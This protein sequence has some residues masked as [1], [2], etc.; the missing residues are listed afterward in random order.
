MHFNFTNKL[1][2]FYLSFIFFVMFSI[3]YF[4]T[5]ISF[6][7]NTFLYTNKNFITE[8]NYINFF[9]NVLSDY[10]KYNFFSTFLLLIIFY[11]L[12]KIFFLNKNNQQTKIYYFT[13]LLNFLIIVCI[14]FLIKDIFYLSKNFYE[15]K[16]INRHIQ[17]IEILN[18][19]R[20][21]VNLLIIFSVIN[22]K[23]NKILS[24]FSYFLIIAYSFLSLSRIELLILFLCH[25]MT[26]IFIT[27]KNIYKIILILAIAIFFIISYRF[28]LS[29]NSLLVIFSEPLHLMLS[30][31]IFFKN[32]KLLSFNDY[33]FNNLYFFLNDFFYFSINVNNYFISSFSQI[34]IYSIRGIDSI[35]C[36]P[37]VFSI[38]LFIL[39][40]LINNFYV[41]K[42]FLNCI[43]S[44]LLIALFRG[45][46]VHNL[47]FIIKI[48]ILIIFFSWIIQKVQQLR[49]RVV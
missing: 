6:L 30:S 8:I 1:P 29:G 34:P 3:Y 49:S 42:P 21:H 41:N 45:N 39:R 24:Y 40:L 9:Y 12:F 37:I 11:C 36:F 22:F 46:F 33:L 44:Y 4:L 23:N 13:Y 20:T 32:I 19:R 28:I 48:Y 17:Y 31:I 5:P 16:E 26:N 25:M 35:I 2:V 27:K 15:M 7:F 43:F 38:Y 10:I 47:N 14:F 18:S